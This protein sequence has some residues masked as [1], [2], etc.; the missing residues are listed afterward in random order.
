MEK[1]KKRV[2]APRVLLAGTGSGCGKTTAVCAVL[3][4]LADRGMRAASFKCGP[5]YI[6]PMFHSR[7]IGAKSGNLDLFFFDGNMA[8]QLLAGGAEGRDVSVIEGAMGY[9]DGAGLASTQASA[10]ELARETGAPAVLIAEARGASLSLLASLEGFVNFRPDSGIQGVIFNRCGAALYTALAEAVRER[11]GGRVEPLGY[12][13]PMPDCGLESRHL[14]LVTAAEVTD[15]RD[16][17]CRLAAQAEKTIDLDGLLKLA[18]SAPPLE[19]EPVAFP[20]FSEPVRVAVASDKAFCFRYED[21]LA[22]LEAMG[23]EL[24]MFSPLEDSALPKN[25]QGLYLCGGYPELYA[26]ELSA[27]RTMGASVREALARGVP[28]IAECGGF[29]YLT[30]AVGGEPMAG[31]LPGKCHDTG[32]LTRFGYVT[33]TAKRDNLLCR[34]GESIRGHEFH[35]WD[36]SDTGGDF[37]AEKASGSSWDCVFASETLYAGFPHFHFCANPRFAEN[38]YRACLK[39]K[40]RHDSEIAAHGD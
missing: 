4:A 15:L 13:P 27:N 22:V 28:C 10:Y 16:K 36:A 14:G 9:Y 3:Q 40:Y 8:R 35:H 38:F 6:D 33:L 37:T 24:A 20:R 25:I 32:R 17:L 30:E 31:V 1:E 11:F 7:V 2:Y 12:L 39:E 34:A 29:M 5:D 18:G 23:A 19:W 26:K 21:S